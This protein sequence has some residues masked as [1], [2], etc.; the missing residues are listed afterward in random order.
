M[1]ENQIPVDTLN[2]NTFEEST[3]GALRRWCKERVQSIAYNYN[4]FH[5]LLSTATEYRNQA[6]YS[7]AAAYA[8]IAMHWIGGLQCGLCCS[9]QPKELLL[10]LGKRAVPASH[11]PAVGPPARPHARTYSTSVHN[12]VPLGGLQNDSSWD[13][14]GPRE[15]P[16]YRAN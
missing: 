15:L 3:Q 14:T 9:G 13:R 4:R 11:L 6:N 10:D 7:L 12:L 1:M 5:E 16:L 8:F 2:I